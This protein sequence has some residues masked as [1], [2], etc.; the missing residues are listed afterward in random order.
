MR[1]S[2]KSHVLLVSEGIVYSF[3]KLVI[4]L[5]NPGQPEWHR[6]GASVCHFAL[7][8]KQIRMIYLTPVMAITGVVRTAVIATPCL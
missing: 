3:L 5:V 2:P 7:G 4:V 6:T 8:V 1:E